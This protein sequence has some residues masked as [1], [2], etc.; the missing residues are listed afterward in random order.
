MPAWGEARVEQTSP[1]ER[2]NVAALAGVE[3]PLISAVADLRSGQ[4]RLTGRI[5][6]I[7]TQLDGQGANIQRLLAA[8]EADAAREA[9]IGRAAAGAL[10]DWL[11]GELPARGRSQAMHGDKRS[12]VAAEMDTSAS[13]DSG[14]SGRQQSLSTD[15]AVGAVGGLSYS[16]AGVTDGS[17][18]LV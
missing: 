15:R 8:R 14:R 17:G 11:S 3:G 4:E 18:S 13:G 6:G 2:G 10:N 5:N 16:G 1:T 9:V 7:Q 12:S